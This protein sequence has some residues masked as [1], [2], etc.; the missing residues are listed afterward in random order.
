[1]VSLSG[2]GKINKNE[3][4]IKELIEEV[5]NIDGSLVGLNKELV[6]EPKNICYYLEYRVKDGMTYIDIILK[7]IERYKKLLTSHGYNL[8]DFPEI[9]QLENSIKEFGK[10]L[11]EFYREGYNPN[12]TIRV[13]III[14]EIR[15]ELSKI[16]DLWIKH[17][18]ELRKLGIIK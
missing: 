3:K 17:R 13:D 8:H 9:H 16:Y 14:R 1:M 11:E 4:L 7:H 15:T 5:E 2:G 18:S 6:E 12:Y 10:K